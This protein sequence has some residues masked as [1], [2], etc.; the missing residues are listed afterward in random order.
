M[1]APTD[2]ITD[3]FVDIAKRGQE[4]VTTAVRTW[5]DTVQSF[6]GTQPTLPD[7]RSFVDTYFD[8]AEKAL[9]HQRETAHQAVAA[10]V[11]A[12]E[13]FAAQAAKVTPQV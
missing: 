5:A 7:A 8:A 4:A 2:Q 12:A 9:A 10:G 3:Q 13:A 6:T 11:K 1:S